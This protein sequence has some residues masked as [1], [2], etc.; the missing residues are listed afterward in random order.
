[1]G[2]RIMVVVIMLVT[3]GVHIIKVGVIIIGNI[4]YCN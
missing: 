2:A 4:D 1:M 3:M